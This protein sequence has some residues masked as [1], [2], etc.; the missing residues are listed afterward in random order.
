VERFAVI[1]LAGG[2]GR[3]FGGPAKPTELVAGVPLLGRVLAAV[4][5][6]TAAVVVG[7]DSLRPL[8]GPGVRLTREEPPGEGPVAATAAGLVLL[9]PVPEVVVVLAA[10]LPFL[11]AATV[12]LLV[13]RAR[14]PG[15]DGAVL[16]DDTGRRQWLCGAWRV[17][18]LAAAIRVLPSPRGRGMRELAAG[19]RI[20]DVDP[21]PG[22]PPD[23][24]DCDTADD[25][26]RAREL[27]QPPR[28]EPP[29]PTAD[30]PEHPGPLGPARA[31]P[32]NETRDQALNE[33]RDR[34]LNETRDRAPEEARDQ[35]RR[36]TRDETRDNGPRQS[37]G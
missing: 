2:A 8:L 6:G 33:T 9:D 37:H 20:E 5:D 24:F 16:V 1:V 14:G 10:D 12:R 13:D 30:Q 3:R 34:A 32:H 17:D 15:V 29:A 35:A 25:L 4:G 18:A 31:D 27:A 22:Q 28:S 26:R 7:P 36:Q 11:T 19:L 23:W 21:G